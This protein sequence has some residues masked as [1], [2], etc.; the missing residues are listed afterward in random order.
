MERR[1]E[2]LEESLRARDAADAA[3]AAVQQFP[4]GDAQ[5][6]VPG[7]GLPSVAAAYPGGGLP[8]AVARPISA[9]MGAVPHAGAARPT[10]SLPEGFLT[11]PRPAEPQVTSAGGAAAAGFTDDYALALALQEEE[12]EAA[13]QQD[14][15][16]G[17]RGQGQHAPQQHQQPQYTATAYPPEQQPHQNLPRAAP[18]RPSSAPEQRQPCQSSGSNCAVM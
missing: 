2:G 3:E 9:L 14:R 10:S 11:L 16:Q 4:L 18:A 1:P 7:R 17:Q 6:C 8:V 5:R 12:V 15:R 13:A